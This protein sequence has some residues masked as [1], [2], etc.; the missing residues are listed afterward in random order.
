MRGIATLL[1]CLLLFPRFL[2]HGHG[3]TAQQVAE[4]KDH[5]VAIRRLKKLSEQEK[6]LIL[7]E[8]K[9]LLNANEEVVFA[10]LYGSMVDPVEPGRYGDIDIALYVSPERLQTPEY[11][12]ESQFEAEA[13]TVLSAK[14]LNF[15]PIEVLIMNHAPYPFLVKLFKS[16]YTV[17]K[18]NEEVMTDFIDEVGL[19]SMANNHFRLESIR[20]LLEG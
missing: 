20:E 10:L 9:N 6:T 14:G 2:Y 19:R 15:P 7:E 11:K 18:E 4:W 16:P 17:L 1:F 5:K 3:T 8:L 13:F 12:L